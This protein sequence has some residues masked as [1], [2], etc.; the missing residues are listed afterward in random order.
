M[1]RSSPFPEP[2][3]AEAESETPRASLPRPSVDA[4]ASLGAGPPP[5]PAEPAHDVVEI[6]MAEEE[7][8]GSAPAEADRRPDD[9]GDPED[10]GP[11]LRAHADVSYEAVEA[12]QDAGLAEDEDDPAPLRAVPFDL[13]ALCA[14]RKRA[15]QEETPPGGHDGGAAAKAARRFQAASLQ[16]G[17]RAQA[18]TGAEAEAAAERELERVF[19]KADFARMR[20]VGQFNLGFILATLGSDLFIV[21]QHASDE[22]HNF[23]RLQRTTALNR[24]PLITPQPLDLSAAEEQTARQHAET[25]NA[26]GFKLVD[27]PDGGLC[28][29][30]APFSKTTT[31]GAGDVQELVALLDGGEAAASSGDVV[32]PSRV[33]A[34]LAMRA[35][36]SS[37][38][39]G[40]ALDKPQMRRVLANLAQLHAP[41]NCPH[42]RPTMRHLANLAKLGK[43]EAAAA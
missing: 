9:A 16:P 24:Q 30:T 41:W 15:R 5:T 4:R 25:F 40:T 39:I 32:R 22:K 10:G 27:G 20:V 28:M 23:E 29:A 8:E 3:E 37:I 2:L 7:E 21:D 33:R 13:D 11:S 26:N 38:M 14:R 42:G 18:A 1:E 12:A 35:C 31:F 36:R 6:D 34:M 43:P 17:V 19:N